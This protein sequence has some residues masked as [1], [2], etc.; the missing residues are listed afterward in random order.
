[1]S[2]H[3]MMDKIADRARMMNENSRSVCSGRGALDIFV[4]LTTIC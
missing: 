4:V 1:M 3:S 2:D